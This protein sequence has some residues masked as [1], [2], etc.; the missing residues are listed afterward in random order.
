MCP[1]YKLLNNNKKKEQ[2]GGEILAEL[3]HLGLSTN[4]GFP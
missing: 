1:P 4:G 2:K 3:H